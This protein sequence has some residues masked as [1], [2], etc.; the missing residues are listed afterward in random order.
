ALLMDA[1][2]RGDQDDINAATEQ[3]YGRKLREAKLAISL[4]KQWSKDEILGAYLNVSQFGPSQYGVETAAQHYYSKSAADLDPDEAAMLDVITHDHNSSVPSAA[5]VNGE[6]RRSEVLTSIH[7]E[8]YISEEEL[9]KYTSRPLED[10]L[11]V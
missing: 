6:M 4:E 9:E 1:V 10:M 8:A 2:Q 7:R 3:S 5:P 11:N